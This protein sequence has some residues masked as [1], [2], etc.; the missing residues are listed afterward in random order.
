[1]G[2]GA[3]V[4][5]DVQDFALV[6]GTPARRIGW[7]GRAGSRLVADGG[8]WRCPV[9]GE[10]YTEAGGT[11]SPRGGPGGQRMRERARRARDAD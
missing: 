1:M 4:T 2:A 8:G 10:R 9:T 3:V 11:L 5:R 6:A 7:V